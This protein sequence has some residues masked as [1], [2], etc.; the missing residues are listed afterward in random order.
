MRD[1]NSKN[2]L[3]VRVFISSSFGADLRRYFRNMDKIFR[4]YLF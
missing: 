2:S 4:S 1:G 3:L